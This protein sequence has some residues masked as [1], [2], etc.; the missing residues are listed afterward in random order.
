MTSIAQRSFAGGEISPTL[1]PRVDTQ[2][3][4]YGAKTMRNTMVRKGGGTQ[5]RPGTTFAGE[6]RDPSKKN[7]MIPFQFSDSQNYVLDFGDQYVRILENG[8]YVSD[9]TLGISGITNANPAVLTYTNPAAMGGLVTGAWITT[10]PYTVGQGVTDGGKLYKCIVSHTAGAVFAVDLAANKWVEIPA[11]GGEVALSGIVG[12]IGT[13]LNGRNFKIA[14]LNSVAKT[15]ELKYLDGTNVNSTAFG[16][17]TSGGSA[18]NIYEI[19]SPFTEAMLT[20]LKYNQENDV[21]R[22]LW[23][24]S[25]ASSFFYNLSRLAATYWQ[26]DVFSFSPATGTP[27]ITGI[28]G[29]AG[30]K[31]L[32]YLVTAVNENGEEGIESNQFDLAAAAEPTAANPAVIT[33]TVSGV[34]DHFR[35]YRVIDKVPGYIGES[36]RTPTHTFT[37]EGFDPDFTQQPILQKTYVGCSAI[38]NYQQRL[39][40]GT[41]DGFLNRIAASQINFANNFNYHRAPFDSDGINASLKHSPGHEIRHFVDIGKLLILTN[42]AEFTAEGNNAGIVTPT[43]LNPRKASGYGSAQIRP[44]EIGGSVVIVQARGNIIRDLGFQFEANGYRGNDLSIFVNHLF[45]GRSITAWAFQ[46]VPD[47]VIW[48]VRDDGVLLGLTYIKEQEIIAWHKHD[49]DGL[50]TDVCVIPEGSEDAVYLDVTRTING[51]TKKYKERMASRTVLASNIKDAVFVDSSLTYDG[52][53]TNNALT[54]T[55]SGGTAWDE[56]EVLTMTA[57]ASFFVSLDIDNRI[58]LI[59]P[60]GTIIRFT[61]EGYTSGTVITG[62][63]HK[64]IPV[65]MR[66]TAISNWAKAVDQL[67]GLWHL[68]GKQVSIFA[69]SFVVASPY[70]PRYASYTVANGS[71]TLAAPYSVITVGLPYISDL[72]TLDIDIGQ[73]ETMAN[74]NKIIN[75]VMVYL[76]KTRGLFIGA[77]APV[78]DEVDALQDLT[79]LKLRSVEGYDSAVDLFT[80]KD[81]VC[82]EPQWNSNGRIFMRQVDPLPVSILAVI[83]NG[84]LPLR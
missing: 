84:F 81:K 47:S 15:F 60:D 35:I 74:K 68:E 4:A 75:E 76:D 59:G 28:T 22:L 2:K 52:R 80:G 46:L 78:D 21:M 38:G 3:Y 45:E 79:E 31:T 69:D 19:V 49:T 72:E 67:T 77:K 7:R 37:D 43:E 70:N 17:Y 24:S 57:S 61:I 71:I 73:G 13:Y 63:P 55:I 50:V 65:T 27:T 53:N 62:R 1:F 6:Q 39:F 40:L 18:E 14:N 66:S 58:D 51:V 8:A 30:A 41:V 26:F 83:P 64:I 44:L 33:W 20:L 34:W 48:V 23:A 5:N 16:A 12:P 11:N 36:R 42:N 82:I 56:S 54:M 29:F 10:F 32:T 9:F 25:A